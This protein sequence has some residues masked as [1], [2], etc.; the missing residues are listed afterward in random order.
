M[1]RWLS[2]KKI[3]LPRVTLVV[4][5][6][7]AAWLL[8][9]SAEPDVDRPGVVELHYWLP[10]H[11][12]DSMRAALDEFERRN[13]Q[14][15]V[16]VGS[17][18]VRDATGDP[19]RFL[20]G[21][22]GGVPPDL[23]YFDRFAVVEW[24]SRGAFT[25]LSPYIEADAGRA[26]AVRPENFFAPA[27]NEAVYRG[28]VF[29]VP[30]SV[31]TR[32]LFYHEDALI[33][34]GFVYAADDPMVTSGRARAGQARPPQ[35]WEELCR[36]RVHAHGRATSDGQ[37]AIEQ[38]VR[39]PGVNEDL[40]EDAVVDMAEVGV[41]AGDVVVLNVK[42][43]VFRVRIAEVLGPTS[44][45]MDLSREQ[46]PDRQN[47]PFEFVGPCEIKV[48]DQ[49]SYLA[50]MSR[51]DPETGVLRSVG[52]I[53][54]FGNS[55]LYM[56]GWLNGARFMSVDGLTCT[57][58]SAEIVYALQY[59]TD[60]YDALGGVKVA[61][62]FE[63]GA[64][65]SV[66]D[67]F[68]TGHVAMR[69]DGNPFMNVIA[70]LRQ[71]LRFGVA[72]SPIP[73]ARRSAGHPSVGWMG[74]WAY[75]V[76]ATAKHKDGAWALLRWLCSQEGVKL[77]TE[78]DVSVARARGR[79]W[80][81]GLHPDRRIMQWLQAEY[82]EK[83]PAL[84][85]HFRDGYQQFVELLPTSKYRPVTPVGQKLWSEHVRAM[86]AAINHVSEPY[87][88]L[89][90]GKRRLQRALDDHLNPPTGPRVPWITLVV[91]YSIGVVGLFAVLAAYQKRK[92]RRLGGGREH[93][94]HGYVCAFPWLL[95][96]VVFG[97]GPILFSIVI[98]FCYYDVL[99]PAR[100]IGFDNYTNLIGFHDD[101]MTG[102]R[103]ANDPL[104]WKSL[105]NTGFMVIGVP[106]GIVCG[107][108]LAMLLD[109]A[110]RGLHF[111]RTVYYLPAIVPAVAGFILWI[112]IF[113]PAR[114]LLN[115]MLAIFGVTHPPHWL[116]DPVWA[117]PSLILMG[118][119][120]VGGGMIIWLAGLKDIPESLYE[121]AKIDGANCWQR[122]RYVTLPMLTPY[123][124]FNLI[125][126]LIGVFQIFEA[127][128]IMTEGGPADA[129]L[130]YAYK[131]FNE[132]F[133]YLNMGAASAMAW[134]LFLVVLVITLWQLWLGKKWVHY[135]R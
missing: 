69:I 52:C 70:N 40:P 36:K 103:V 100:F 93:W 127:A 68:L 126:G 124:F 109:T 62:A 125:M 54:L 50:R 15:R 85:Q 16:I 97:A 28:K 96:F 9:P 74:G 89:N 14:Y 46:P 34:A 19:T 105:M 23:I 101:A 33:R 51:Y 30:L 56:Y 53:P 73:E 48:F 135:E 47:I 61:R 25:D 20:L 95:G 77:Q 49:D 18:T 120:G 3:G 75:A 4:V 84:S 94:M 129:T 31:D 67:P 60:M 64:R 81:P 80:I 122:F 110:V 86:E 57:L 76:P 79:T 113:D 58:D 8:Y 27:W 63:A 26:D 115:Q 117:K 65:S 11:A 90:Y 128:Y 134:I 2:V 13:P 21:V 29:A 35:T 108:A 44:L 66:I 72:P 7:V 119:W 10:T 107:L 111:Y 87:E 78:Y 82:I 41:R 121:A 123:I 98:S 116:Q 55:W 22:A 1:M 43:D 59:L 106:I 92:R 42:D 132:A 114:G 104:F 32:A 37:V 133:R 130:F 83:N 71:D 24:A 102:Q 39:R 118:L 45:Q 88:S 17:A 112:W 12:L 38:W 99:T 6:L 131:L 5:A 91:I